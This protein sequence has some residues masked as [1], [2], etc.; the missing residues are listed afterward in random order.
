MNRYKTSDI[1]IHKDSV[2]GYEVSHRYQGT[3]IDW[4]FFNSRQEARRAG[5]EILKQMKEDAY[6]T[7]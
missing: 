1:R 5:V 7:L 2:G 6:E 4:D 3:L